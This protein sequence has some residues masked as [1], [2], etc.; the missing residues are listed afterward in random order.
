[1]IQIAAFILASATAPVTPPPNSVFDSGFDA[2]ALECPYAISSPG[3]VR[4][5]LTSSDIVYL[6]IVSH[7]RPG[8]DISNFDNIW[9]HINELDG[10]TPWPG[11]R[12]AS[13]TIR[14]IGHYQ[15][16]GAKFRVPDSA[17]S[18]L[19]GYFKHVSYGGG[20]N[21]D[22]AISTQCGDF[23]PPQPACSA[24]DVVSDDY[25]MVRWGVSSSSSAE[26]HL[27]PGSVYYVNIR[28][29]DPLTHGPDCDNG[30]VTCQ[31]TIQQYY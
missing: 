30:T 12:G 17:S 20:P 1:M 25:S 7:L 14:R 28:F 11:A 24:A 13:P 6:P 5:L 10:V 3:G 8:V 2:S 21:I 31:T 16:I 9:G 26:C 4:T 23:H 18:S 27:E 22:F 15:Y 29:T 19:S